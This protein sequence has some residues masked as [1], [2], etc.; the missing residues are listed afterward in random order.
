MPVS[1]LS[2]RVRLR[3]LVV[4]LCLLMFLFNFSGGGYGTCRIYSELFLALS[5]VMRLIS[6]VW[7][8]TSNLRRIIPTR[9]SI[10]DMLLTW[11]CLNTPTSTFRSG[12]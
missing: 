12:H 11:K 7:V 4:K 10:R 5:S 9:I 8:Y 1:R 6:R 2:E 3:L